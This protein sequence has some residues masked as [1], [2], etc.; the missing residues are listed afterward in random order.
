MKPENQ[1]PEILCV[2]RIYCD[3]VFS[4]VPRMPTPGSEVF[5]SDVSLHA[6]GGA[7][8]SAVALSVLG[9][10][11][12]LSGYLPAAPFDAQIYSEAKAVGLDLSLCQAALA[13][14]APQITVAMA[15]D[16]DRSFLTNKTGDAAPEL[17]VTR[18]ACQS[19][20]H[21]HIGEIR[22]LIERPDLLTRATTAGWTVSLDCGWDDE[23]MKQGAALNDLVSRVDVFLPNEIEFETLQSSGLKSSA[24]ILTVVKQGASGATA[25]SNGQRLHCPATPVQVVDAT[26]AGDAFNGGFLSEWLSGNPLIA[27]L[28]K[29]NECGEKTVLQTG[30]TLGLLSQSPIRQA[31]SL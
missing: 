27:C 25:M 29:G 16:G 3:L 15:M 20:R 2:G 6:G 1:G 24:A 17:D 13:G 21:L 11:T 19:I 14:A 28:Q 5:A 31:S 12:A 23:V 22:T 7:F 18:T 8:N 10:K 9:W 4:G 26:G 30:G